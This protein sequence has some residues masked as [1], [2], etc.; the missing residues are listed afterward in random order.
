MILL[1]WYE[2]IKIFNRV[3]ETKPEIMIDQE[4][5]RLTGTV[6]TTSLV[7]D[8]AITLSFALI[9][10]DDLFEFYTQGVYDVYLNGILTASAIEKTGFMS[11]IME[12]NQELNKTGLSYESYLQNTARQLFY[13]VSVSYITIYLAVIFLIVANTFVGVQFLMSQ[14]NAKRRYRTL[15]RLGATHAAL[16]RSSRKQ[17]NWYFGLPI[18]FA[19]FSCLFGVRSLLTGFLPDR[20]KSNLPEMMIVSASIILVLCV[21]EYIYITAVKRANDRYL[22]TLLIPEREE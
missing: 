14:Q 5:F 15:I 16:C 22:L 1:F 11:A 4:T 6:Q 20:A 7:T 13:M 18:T 17:V 8:R 2:R 21:I 12:M 3:L 9:L 10:P 19:A